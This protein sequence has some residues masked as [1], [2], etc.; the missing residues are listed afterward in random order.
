MISASIFIYTN[1]F[2]SEETNKKIIKEFIVS[3]TVDLGLLT[4]Q[5]RRFDTERAF[6]HFDSLQLKKCSML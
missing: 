2:Q 1:R 4:R 5:N 3:R 6:I